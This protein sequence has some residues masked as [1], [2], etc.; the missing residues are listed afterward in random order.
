[1]LA[2]VLSFN[3]YATWTAYGWIKRKIKIKLAVPTWDPC[4]LPEAAPRNF[5]LQPFLCKIAQNGANGNET[6]AS[7]EVFGKSWIK[8]TQ[9][10][11]LENIKYYICTS[12]LTNIDIWSFTRETFDVKFLLIF[13]LYLDLS[14]TVSNENP[15]ISQEIITFLCRACPV[16]FKVFSY[17]ISRWKLAGRSGRQPTSH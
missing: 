6:I 1:M 17:S 2:R 13:L 8:V 11:Y 3:I 7:W 4:C 14:F 5:A 12:A 15:N 16:I 9:D 10:F